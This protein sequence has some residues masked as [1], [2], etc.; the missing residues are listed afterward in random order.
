[1]S[2]I[3]TICG[4]GSMSGNNVSHSKRHTKRTWKPNLVKVKIEDGRKVS[5]CTRCRKSLINSSKKTS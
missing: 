1:M 4:K 2:R 3:C 5:L